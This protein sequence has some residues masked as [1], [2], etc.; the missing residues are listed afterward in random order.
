[1]KNEQLSNTQLLRV[2]SRAMR[3]LSAAFA[4]TDSLPEELGTPVAED[5]V[6]SA[7]EHAATALADLAKI[8]RSLHLARIR[9]RPSLRELL[10]QEAAKP[11]VFVA[12]PMPVRP[13][14]PG[15]AIVAISA[16][17]ECAA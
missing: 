12:V 13:Y 9:E 4:L 8:K 17:G 10:K 3:G 16:R 14:N 7:M 1:M 11:R 2:A 5:F 15:T 6:Q